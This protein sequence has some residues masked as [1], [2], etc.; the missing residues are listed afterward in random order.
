[1]PTTFKIKFK[2]I[3]LGDATVIQGFKYIFIIE[4]S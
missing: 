3:P 4:K 2:Y 1:M